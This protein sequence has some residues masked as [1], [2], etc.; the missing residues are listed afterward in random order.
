MA[1]AQIFRILGALLL[2]LMACS[3]APAVVFDGAVDPANLGEGDWIYVLANE[4]NQLEGVVPAVTNVQSLMSYEAS[5]GMQWVVVKASD[6]SAKYPS[7]AHPQFTLDVILA[8]HR[9]GLQIFGWNRS[10]GTDPNGEVEIAKWVYNLG[11]DGLVMDAEGEWETSHTPPLGTTA[12]IATIATNI[13]KNIKDLYPTKFMAYSPAM[14]I[15]Y[16]STFPY[17]VYGQYCDAVMPMDYWVDFG[18]TPGN[19]VTNWPNGLDMESQWKTWQNGLSAP[20]K[21]LSIK[22]IVPAGSA[23]GGSEPGSDLTTFVNTLKGLA[24]PATA[25]GYKGVSWWRAGQHSLDMLNAISNVN[26]GGPFPTKPAVPSTPTGLGA[27]SPGGCFVNLTWNSAANANNYIISRS[28]THNGPYTDIDSS[29]SSPWADTTGVNANTPYYYVVRAANVSG[30]SASSTEA[31]VTTPAPIYPASLTNLTA[32]TVGC[33]INLAWSM[34]DNVA[35]YYN[36]SR[37][38]ATGGP[39]I[40]IGSTTS[41]SYADASG[42]QSTTYHYVVR[43]A[44]LCGQSAA[45][46]PEAVATTTAGCVADILMD[47]ADSTGVVFVNSWSTGSSIGRYLTDYRYCSTTTGSAS[48]SATYTPT[49]L[50]AGWY[51]ISIWY[52]PGSNRSSDARHTVTYTNGSTVTVTVDQSQGGSTWQL[53]T[54]ASPKY[55]LA[56]TSGNVQI[57]NV[58]ANSTV[59]NVMADG[60]KFSY[61]SK[62][63]VILFPAVTNVIYGDPAPTATAS[64]GLAVTYTV[65]SGPAY[66]SANKVTITNTGTVTI[67]AD[68]AGNA[69]FF[70]APSASLTFTVSPNTLKIA[71]TTTNTVVVS[72]PAPAGGWLLER[73]NA[74]PRT[75]ASWPQISPPY[76]TN[77]TQAWIVAPSPTGPNY[78]RLRKP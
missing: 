35:T 28:T 65:L 6:G 47:N 61:S 33:Q 57:D 10:D 52:S 31:G 76:Q 78:Y 44:N 18:I 2:C 62:N 38:T 17:K 50:T 16:H 45:Y 68:Q 46:S 36:V 26:I 32:T 73:T 30:E 13:L 53:L 19:C 11:A 41:T 54:G 8:A 4:I 67:K 66:I 60:V 74:L 22:P 14:V 34:A 48:R 63:Q 51:D 20:Y 75:T 69:S 64:S 39:Y 29:L 23:N 5:L 37:G 21:T 49:I 43:A 70:P 15:T 7:A 55:F 24:N 77:T 9:A 3:S 72:W 56:G 12:Q 1:T 40:F 71:P 58:S 59:K 27:A 25:G 42:A